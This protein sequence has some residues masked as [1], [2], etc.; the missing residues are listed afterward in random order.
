MVTEWF[1]LMSVMSGAFVP[2]DGPGSGWQDVVRTRHAFTSLAECEQARWEQAAHY[3]A[4]P[5]EG[6]GVVITGCQPVHRDTGR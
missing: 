1:F 5:V 4:H 2:G 6:G 3:R